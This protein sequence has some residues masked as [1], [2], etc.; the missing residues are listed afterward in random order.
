MGSFLTNI[1]DIPS[2]RYIDLKG[3]VGLVKIQKNRDTEEVIL[4]TDDSYMKPPLN[5]CDSMAILSL[6]FNRGIELTRRLSYGADYYPEDINKFSVKLSKDHISQYDPELF[7]KVHNVINSL[8]SSSNTNR[9]RKGRKLVNLLSI[10][11]N[12]LLMYPKFAEESYLNLVRILEAQ[13]NNGNTSAWHFPDKTIPLLPKAFI[14][15]FYIEIQKIDYFK[16]VHIKSAIKFFSRNSNII[17]NSVKNY[18]DYGKGELKLMYVVLFALYEYRNKYIHE[19][20]QFP[21]KI[22]GYYEG[23]GNEP[24]NYLDGSLGE[25]FA[26]NTEPFESKD[27]H[28]V[29]NAKLENKR[30]RK[31]RDYRSYEILYKFLPKWNFLNQITREILFYHIKKLK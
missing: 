3:K 29:L 12:A 9:N 2:D 23:N 28:K 17:K 18:A 15:K 16:T 8:C 30:G 13:R 24:L 11:K 14:S 7:E 31:K 1:T 22:T 19:G 25:G 27:I 21:H 26:V 6:L 10:Y 4:Y 5:H 20:F